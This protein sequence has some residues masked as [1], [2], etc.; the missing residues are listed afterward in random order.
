MA[1]PVR[2]PWQ[3]GPS[4]RISATLSGRI[5]K[6]VANWNEVGAFWSLSILSRDNEPLVQGVKLTAGALLTA[7]LPD[8]RLPQGY[9]V[10]TT[11][12]ALTAPP[13]RDDMGTNAELIYVP[14]V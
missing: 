10:V 11:T 14:A 12:T 5:Y 13:G 9:F 8:R 3:P 4:W 2:I 6:L 1:G 7:R